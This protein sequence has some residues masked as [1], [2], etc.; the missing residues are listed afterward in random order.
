MKQAL[1]TALFAIAAL[2]ALAFAS[3]AFASFAPKLVV[4]STDVGGPTRIGV[5]ISNTDDPT[6]QALIYVP[7]GYA[8]GAP[9]PGTKLG[10]VTATVSAAD[11]NGQILP[12]TGELDAIAPTRSR[13]AGQQAVAACSQSGT[14]T[15]TGTCTVGVTARRSTSRCLVD[16]GNR[17]GDRAPATRRSS[18]SA[19]R[20]PTCRRRHPARAVFGAKLLS[21]TFASSAISE[22]SH[23]RRL[24]L[25]VAVDA[26]HARRRRRRTRPERSRRSRSVH[27][28][29]VI[30]HVFTSKKRVVTY[31]HVTKKKRIKVKVSHS[32]EVRVERDRRRPPLRR[33]R[34]SSC[35]YKGKKIGGATGSLTLEAESSRRRLTIVAAIDSDTGS[36]PTGVPDV[37]GRSLLPRPGASCVHC[38][39]RSSGPPVH[40]RDGRRRR[41]SPAPTRSRRTRSSRG[42]PA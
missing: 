40:R 25:D 8:I 10:D 29:R 26:V 33:G 2:T 7:N 28:R 1:R 30:L 19:C 20:R 41:S 21:A 34:P 9:A 32:G 31:K 39:A 5:V 42:S 38:D 16:P 14:P 3:S 12:L 17:H 15:Q 13:P 36:V 37:A 22:P 11:L 35:S 4:S 23:N 18:S 27:L 6:A 24:S